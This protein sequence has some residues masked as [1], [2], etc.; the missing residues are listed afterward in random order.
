M[1][2]EQEPV[3]DLTVKECEELAA[4]LVEDR[5]G[6][7]PG[8]EQES[9]LKIAQGYLE[10]AKLK[11]LVLGKSELSQLASPDALVEIDNLAPIR[12]RVR[13]WPL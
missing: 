11:R 12:A 7:S 13:G 4:A 1:N 9:I 5:A 6:L 8:P 10:L 2:A 3:T